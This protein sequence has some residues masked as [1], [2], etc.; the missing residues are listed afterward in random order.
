MSVL[1]ALVA[2]LGWGSSDFAAGHASRK[3][4]A[5]SVVILTHLASVI[6]LLVVAV[7]FGPDGFSIEKRRLN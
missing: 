4:S 2:A 6:A 3:S 7:R 5:T 1:F